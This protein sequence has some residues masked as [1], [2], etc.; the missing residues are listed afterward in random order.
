MVSG[1]MER[2]MVEANSSGQ[3]GQ[4]MMGITCITKKM[5]KAVS[6]FLQGTTT[7]VFGRMDN[8]M[9]RV[10]YLII[11]RK[12]LKKGFGRMDSSLAICEDECS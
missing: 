1:E 3:M 7:K 8:N 2:C 10:S 4:A 9:G 6:F 12:K 5:D 11:G